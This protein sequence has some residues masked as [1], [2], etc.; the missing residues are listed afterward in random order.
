MPSTYDSR[1]DQGLAALL[2]AIAGFGGVGL[3]LAVQERRARAQDQRAAA[4]RI[5]RTR[6]M[7][8][9]VGADLKWMHTRIRHAALDELGGYDRALLSTKVWDRYGPDICADLPLNVV[10]KLLVAYGAVETAMLGEEEGAS[11][12]IMQD[13]A[14][15]R[16]TPGGTEKLE[17]LR[18]V[19][20]KERQNLLEAIADGYN[21]LRPY[22]DAGRGNGERSLPPAEPDTRAVRSGQ[23]NAQGA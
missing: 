14:D 22:F 16:Q 18:A 19:L 21:A 3:S 23:A 15:V 10:D 6:G 9:M 11:E 20:E 2:G 17:K 13:M 7:A 12:R 1:V 8:R 4:E 5:G